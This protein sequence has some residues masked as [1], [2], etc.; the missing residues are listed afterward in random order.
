MIFKRYYCE[1]KPNLGLGGVVRFSSGFFPGI[2]Q[3]PC[4]NQYLQTVIEGHK[5]FGRL[6]TVVS[7][8]NDPR[9]RDGATMAALKKAAIDARRHQE[10]MANE[11]APQPPP[12]PRDVVADEER[13]K[14]KAAPPRE[15]ENPEDVLEKSD[16]F[17]LA[18]D[19]EG[20]GEVEVVKEPE[21]PETRPEPAKPKK[22]VILVVPSKSRLRSMSKAEI[23]D[24]AY[25][26]KIDL[27]VK[28]TKAKWLMV[29]HGHFKDYWKAGT[30]EV[31]I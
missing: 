3:P 4:G 6:I 29:M 18:D 17:S 21:A 24:T 25:R 15:P 19:S 16:G 20:D 14:R 1:H 23:A 2:G 9:E 26:W 7:E 12:R 8:T 27:P 28:G 5:L 22:K 31:T 13:E 30:K 11:K 10:E